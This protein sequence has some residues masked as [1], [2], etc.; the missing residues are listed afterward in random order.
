M[1]L[2]DLSGILPWC[3]DYKKFQGYF[4][5]EDLCQHHIP[6]WCDFNNKLTFQVIDA[7]SYQ[8]TYVAN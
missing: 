4:S 5:S 8:D 7:Y 6:S 3:M 2:C 1:K